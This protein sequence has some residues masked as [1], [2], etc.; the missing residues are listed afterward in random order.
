[1]ITFLRVIKPT[2]YKLRLNIEITIHILRLSTSLKGVVSGL[3]HTTR[4]PHLVPD[5]KKMNVNGFNYVLLI[6]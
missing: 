3:R 1:M 6:H 2:C 5:G 4:L